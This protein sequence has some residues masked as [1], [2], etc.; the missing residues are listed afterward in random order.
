MM[1]VRNGL[2]AGGLEGDGFEPSVPARNDIVF[3]RPCGYRIV[4][5]KIVA[6]RSDLRKR[7]VG[8]C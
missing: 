3:E 6:H 7:V 4:I 8:V 1:Q 5:P 2:A